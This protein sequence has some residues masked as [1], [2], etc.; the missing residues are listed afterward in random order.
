VKVSYK[1]ALG[2]VISSLC[3][4]LMFLT[5]VFPLL[6]LTLPIFSGMLL[7][8]VAIEI[9]FTWGFLTY[10]AVAILSVFI[11]PDKEAAILFI[12]FF[13]YY[14]ILKALLEKSLKKFKAVSWAIKFAVFN[15]AIIAAYY[16]IIIVL[17]TVDMLE[18]FDFLGEYMVAGLLGFGNLIFILYDVTLTLAT[19]T[20]LKWFRPTF[21]KK[22]K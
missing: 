7:I 11:T 10:A 3:L 19:A 16:I 5:A 4:L 15:I 17:G 13:G 21:L 14:P 8:M 22:I 18:E 6:A 20:Y 1:V 12:L 9:N 2:G